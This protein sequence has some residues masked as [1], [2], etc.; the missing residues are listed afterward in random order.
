MYEENFYYHPEKYGLTPVGE[1]SWD[2]AAY[3]FD[4]TVVYH[5]KEDG[6]FLYASDSGCSCPSPFEDHELSDLEEIESL[7]AFQT[8]L[9]GHSSRD[10]QSPMEIVNLLEKLHG[11]GLR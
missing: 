4:F 9:N 6:K 3:Q 7:G 8:W 11:L 1:V 10:D 5:R 2:D